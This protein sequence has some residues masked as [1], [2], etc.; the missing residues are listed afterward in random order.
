MVIYELHLIILYKLI[1][2]LNN[3][4]SYLHELFHHNISYFYLKTLWSIQ[5]T[6]YLI[7]KYM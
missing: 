2:L 5:I 4:K 1:N 7:V 6:R 3:F